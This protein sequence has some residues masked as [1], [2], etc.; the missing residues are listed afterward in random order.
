MRIFAT[1]LTLAFVP[2]ASGPATAKDG[3]NAA[4]I[5]G[6]AAGVVGGVLLNEALQN[7]AAAA[8]VYVERVADDPELVRLRK[9]RRAC[10]AGNPR[11][12]VRLGYILGQNRER[13]RQWR[14]H[15]PDL[16]DF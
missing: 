15:N 8:P 2:L 11:T 13:E 6:A 16:F 7:R 1:L 4:F 5:G 10:Y 9:L 3:R 12:C 14:R